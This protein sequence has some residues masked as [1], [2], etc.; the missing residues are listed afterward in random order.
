MIWFLFALVWVGNLAACVHMKN[1]LAACYASAI[2]GM[3][4]VFWLLDKEIT[5]L[6]K[7]K[8]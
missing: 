2:I 6:K 3:M 7:E 5:R 8:K 1:W 4:Y